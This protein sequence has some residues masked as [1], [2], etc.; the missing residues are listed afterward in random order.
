MESLL[1]FLSE[2]ESDRKLLDL[3][4]SKVWNLEVTEGMVNLVGTGV[5]VLGG[6]A[7][8]ERGLRGLV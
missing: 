2:S 5:K 4:W 7:H 1:F 3:I 8:G 6:E